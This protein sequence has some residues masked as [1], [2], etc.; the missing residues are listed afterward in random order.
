[1]PVDLPDGE[2]SGQ[3][4][5]LTHAAGCRN[6]APAFSRDGSRVAFASCQAGTTHNIWVMDSNGEHAEPLTTG[7]ESDYWPGW[8]PDGKRVAFLSQ[9]GGRSALW[10]VML[11]DRREAKIL[12]LS[13]SPQHVCLSPDGTSI[14]FTADSAGVRNVWV[15]PIEGASP[16]QVTFDR[17]SA[18]F[19]SWSPDGRLLALN[20]NHGSDTQIAVIPASGGELEVLTQGAGQAWT[21][22]WSPDGERILFAGQ[23][24]GLWNLYWISKRGGPEHRLTDYANR[25]SFVRYPAWSPRGNQIVY[26]YAETTG[27]VWLMDLPR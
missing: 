14:V 19:A 25:H 16:R 8:F 27:N 20:V 24:D 21:G 10:S 7:L 2:P 22:N 3:P 18:G 17:E 1:L 5:L 26:E 15:T 11:A 12:D 9:R 6:T 13:S 23:R 4:V